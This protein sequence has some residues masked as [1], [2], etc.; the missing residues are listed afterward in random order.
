MARRSSGAERTWPWAELSL[1]VAAIASVGLARAAVALIRHAGGFEI[2]PVATTFSGLSTIPHHLALTGEGLLMLF[3]AEF[4]GVHS[5]LDL[6]IAA[7]HLIGVAAAAVALCLAAARLGRGDELAVRRGEECPF[8]KTYR[9]KQPVPVSDALEGCNGS[10]CTA[11]GPS[12]AV[13]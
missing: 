7:L 2:Q 11:L 5:P 3:G 8:R 9:H 12:E 10:S 1:A 13:R 4:P 6:A